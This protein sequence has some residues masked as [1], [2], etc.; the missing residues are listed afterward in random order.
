MSSKERKNEVICHDTIALKEVEEEN[1]FFVKKYLRRKFI[2]KTGLF[3]HES[4][5]EFIV[6]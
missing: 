5:A 2:K 4:Q 3:D 1:D 6:A